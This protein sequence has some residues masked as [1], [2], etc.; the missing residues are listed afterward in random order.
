MNPPRLGKDFAMTGNILVLLGL[1]S[2]LT[3]QSRRG[4]SRETEIFDYH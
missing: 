4:I 2:I 1:K 3:P